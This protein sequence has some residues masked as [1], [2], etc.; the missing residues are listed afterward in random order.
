MVIYRLSN[1]VKHTRNKKGGIASGT[2][3]KLQ[4]SHHVNIF[5]FL[6]DLQQKVIPPSVSTRLLIYDVVQEQG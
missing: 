5:R 1:I 6:L 2:H 4:T 3:K